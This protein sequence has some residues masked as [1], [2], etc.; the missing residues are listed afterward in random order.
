VR[1]A[2]DDLRFQREKA[3]PGEPFH[4]IHDLSVATPTIIASNIPLRELARI[5]D[6]AERSLGFPAS[7]AVG[8]AAAP[9]ASTVPRD[10]SVKTT[11]AQPPPL[12]P[13][14]PLPSPPSNVPS[15]WTNVPSAVTKGGTEPPP[16]TNRPVGDEDFAFD[17][18]DDNSG[19]PKKSVA[20]AKR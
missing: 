20:A 2:I 13:P 10:A 17:D 5:L 16:P 14:P 19:R 9:N 8:R 15:G 6:A 11:D 18:D 12:Q 1:V 3:K 4:S 7:P